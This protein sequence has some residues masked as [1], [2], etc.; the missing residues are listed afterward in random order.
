MKIIGT[1]QDNI[2]YVE[3]LAVRAVIKNKKN[4]IIIIHIAKGNYYKLPG[5]GIEADEAHLPALEREV[6]EETGCN[7]RLGELVAAVEE[8]RND[9]HQISYCYSGELVEDTGSPELTELEESEG[10][11]HEWAS[12]EEA[13]K[14]MKDIQPSSELGAFIKE[15]DLYLLACANL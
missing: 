9:L 6:M 13:L 12:V 5:G 8:W 14:K 11:K 15:R 2:K 3:R 1:K 7:V 10:L 4:E